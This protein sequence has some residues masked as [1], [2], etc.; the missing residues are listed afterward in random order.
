MPAAVA[1]V[2]DVK[3][4]VDGY[5]NLNH[6]HDSGSDRVSTLGEAMVYATGPILRRWARW[7][8]ASGQVRSFA[9]WAFHRLSPSW[10]VWGLTPVRFGGDAAPPG[11]WQR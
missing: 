5:T 1:G 9:F 8:L 7:P 2:G 11:Y 10:V 4:L 6:S 3:S